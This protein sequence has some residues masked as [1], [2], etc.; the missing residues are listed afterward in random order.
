M[1]D[2]SF[3]Y[4]MHV[5]HVMVLGL[6]MI[7]CKYSCELVSTISLYKI[8]CVELFVSGTMQ[9]YFLIVSYL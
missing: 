9:I 6:F 2:Y 4:V 5:I 8:P 7:L 3:P 1:I